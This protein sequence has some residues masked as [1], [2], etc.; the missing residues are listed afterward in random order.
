MAQKNLP[1]HISG[2]MQQNFLQHF[3][4]NTINNC[5][6]SAVLGYKEAE[7]LHTQWSNRREAKGMPKG[8]LRIL[9][10][11]MFV[12]TVGT[13]WSET[14]SVKC[15]PED[16]AQGCNNIMFSFENNVLSLNTS[17]ISTQGGSSVQRWVLLFSGNWAVCGSVDEDGNLV[18]DPYADFIVDNSGGYI[19][20]SPETPF[21]YT[22]TLLLGASF[23]GDGAK[24]YYDYTFGE[25]SGR[26]TTG[27]LVL[28]EY[29][30]RRP[31][32]ADTYT[33]KS[34]TFTAVYEPVPEPSSILTLAIVL[35][36]AVSMGLRRAKTGR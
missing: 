36:G 33:K 16:I 31:L 6:A 32:E 1:G 19:N 28:W 25:P 23:I 7:Q 17:S 4:Y 9:V 34:H 10:I 8:L 12:L 29:F 13:A 30:T 20:W 15:I 11:T 18:K 5:R 14:W 22:T 24:T 3:F 27:T 26:E 2:R 21:G 35:S